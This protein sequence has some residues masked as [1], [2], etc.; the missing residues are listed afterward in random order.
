MKEVRKKL[1]LEVEEINT[2]MFITEFENSQQ[3][4]LR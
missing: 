2:E 4:K 3:A 1:K